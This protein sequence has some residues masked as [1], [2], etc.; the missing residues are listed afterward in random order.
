MKTVVIELTEEERDDVLHVLSVV[1]MMPDGEMRSNVESAI[2]KL[3]G[4]ES[5]AK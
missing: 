1:A 2:R 5:G 3:R 4:S